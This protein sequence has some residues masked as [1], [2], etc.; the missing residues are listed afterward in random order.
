MNLFFLPSR[1]IALTIP[2]MLVTGFIAGL[3]LNTSFLKDYILLVT[4]LIMIYPTM[5]G[6]KTNE[7]INT[8]HTR[9]LLAASV[10]NFILVPLL[11]YVLGVVFLLRDPQLFAGLAIASLLPTSNMTIAFTHFGRGNIPA[12]VKLTVISLVF[13]SLLAPWYLYIMVGGYIEIN[14]LAML[15]TVSMVIFLPLFMGITTYNIILKKYTREEFENTVKPYLPALSAWGMVYVIFTGISTNAHTIVSKPGLLLVSLMV[16]VFFY[17]FNYMISIK[18]G[19]RYFNRQDS[20]TLVFGTVL[21][22]LAISI[23]LAATAFGVTA[24][25]MVSLAFLF[26]GQSAA[27]FVRLNEKY[28]ILPEDSADLRIKTN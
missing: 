18:A 24:A 15:Q 1:N 27:W 8:S 20:V 28:N 22:N 3:Y 14:V 26:Q 13:G 23:G 19:R 2:V 12:A 16:W 5:I 10:I 6:F 17:A 4:V 7:I 9:L 21:R 11:A 25:F